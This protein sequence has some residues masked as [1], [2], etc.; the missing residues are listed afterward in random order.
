MANGNNIGK[1]SDTFGDNLVGRQFTDGSSQFT[2]GN[3]GINSGARAKDSREFSLGN[4]SEP[5]TLSTLNFKSTEEARKASSNS[6]EVFINYDRS[7]VSN[8]VLYGSL[9]DRLRVAVQ[10]VIKNFPAALVFTKLRQN[11]LT[12]NTATNIIFDAIEN[13]TT[14]DLELLNVH[15]PFGIDFTKIGKIYTDKDLNPIRNFTQFYNKYSL[16]IRDEEYPLTFITP[17]TGN[18]VTDTLSIEVY[19]NPFTGQTTTTENFFIKPNT[20]E[21]EEIFDN[22][23]DVEKFII[24][25]DTTPIYTANFD[26]P[27]QTDSGKFVQNTTSLT[28]PSTNSWNL[29]ITGASFNVYLNKLLEIADNFDAYKTN[30]VSRFLTTAAFKEFDTEDEKVDQILKIYGRSFDNIKTYIEGLAYMTNVTYDS[31]NNVP[32]ELL[33]NFAHMLGWKTPSAIETEGFLESI[34]TRSKSEY[35][36]KAQSQTPTELNSELYRRLVVNTAYLFKSKGT[37]K[38][39]EFLM[40][41]VGAPEALIEFNEHVYVAG[42]RVNMQKFNQ[43]ISVISGGSYYEEVIVKDQLFSATT[44]TFPPVT[45]TGYTF[46]TELVSV[47]T[48]VTRAQFPVDSQGY[49]LAPTFNKDGF[50]QAGAGWFEETVEHR[51]K[52]M[53]DIQT[54]VFTGNT[55]SVK[56]KLNKFT[57]GEPYL[58]LYRKF[59]ETNL[60]FDIIRTKDNKKSWVY[61]EGEKSKRLYTF[62]DRG[63]RYFTEDERLVLNVKNVDL[64]LN[65]GQGLTWDV[66]N[67]SNKFG[68]PFGKDPL[69]P[70]YPNLGGPDWTQIQIDASKIPF[71]EFADQFWKILINVKNR[72][73]IDD[74]HAGGYPTLLKVY[75]DYL[76]SDVAC[77]VPSNKYTYQKMIDYAEGIGDY[78]MRLVEQFIP[79]TT[80]WQGGTRYENSAF[81][82]YKYSYKHEPLC[83][84][85]ECFGSFISC[86]GPNFN[87]QLIDGFLGCN[88]T[89]F[90]GA[91]WSN[92][93]TLGGTVYNGSANG[94]IYYSSTTLTDIPSTS[95][96]LDDVVS[97]LSGI[98]QDVSDPNNSLTWYVHDDT[99]TDPDLPFIDNPKTIIVQGPCSEGIDMWNF[100]DGPDPHTFEL[101]T[102]LDMDVR[103]SSLVDLDMD[104]FV[105]Y[106]G[107]SMG[108]TVANNAKT[109]LQS[110]ASGLTG[111][112][113]NIYHIV[114]GAERWLCSVQYPWTGQM[115]CR[116]FNSVNDGIAWGLWN[117]FCELPNPNSEPYGQP[118][119]ITN[120]T[121]YANSYGSLGGQIGWTGGTKKALNIILQDETDFH[122]HGSYNYIGPSGQGR[123]SGMVEGR[124]RR[125][126]TP[127][128]DVEDW[129]SGRLDQGALIGKQI[130]T[131][132]CPPYS[133]SI[134]GYP[135]TFENPFNINFQ[136]DPPLSAGDAGSTNGTPGPGLGGGWPRINPGAGGC[137]IGGE[138]VGG[139]GNVIQPTVQYSGDFY[140]FR[141]VYTNFDSFLGFVYPI[142]RDCNGART[143]FPLHVYG[144][145]ERNTVNQA[146]LKVNPLIDSMLGSMS[147]ITKYNPYSGL[148]MYKSLYPDAV[149]SAVTVTTAI[150][151][152]VTGYTATTCFISGAT[153]GPGTPGIV[154]NEPSGIFEYSC[155]ANGDPAT[156]TVH[157]DNF[158]TAIS[159]LQIS[160]TGMT[161]DGTNTG[162]TANQLACENPPRCFY[163]ADTTYKVYVNNA[164]L[165][166][167]LGPNVLTATTTIELGRMQMNCTGLDS[168]LEQFGWGWQHNLGPDGTV[169]ATGPVA[170]F[171]AG[172]CSFTNVSQNGVSIANANPNYTTT[173]PG[174]GSVTGPLG[175]DDS[176]FFNEGQFVQDLNQFLE[177]QGAAVSELTGCTICLPTCTSECSDGA[178]AWSYNTYYELGDTVLG[179]HGNCYV[180][181]ELGPTLTTNPEAATGGPIQYWQ[182]A[183]NSSGI[184]F[185]GGNNFR[186]ADDCTDFEEVIVPENPGGTGTTTTV[187]PLTF[188]DGIFNIGGQDCFESTYSPCLGGDN[189]AS[190]VCACDAIDE[191]VE[192]EYEVG[193]I[194]CC[195]DGTAGFAAGVQWILQAQSTTKPPYNCG[196]QIFSYDDFCV[197][198]VEGSTPTDGCWTP[199]TETVANLPSIRQVNPRRR[200][201]LSL[202]VNDPRDPC[203]PESEVADTPSGP[204]GCGCNSASATVLDLDMT[205]IGWSEIPVAVMNFEMNGSN[206]DYGLSLQNSAYHSATDSKCWK[207]VMSLC[208]FTDYFR[209]HTHV[210][211]KGVNST[212]DYIKTST[213]EINN[214]D[215]NTLIEVYYV[216]GSHAYTALPKT[217]KLFL[218]IPVSLFNSQVTQS[219]Y[220]TPG[221]TPNS[222]EVNN[223]I[224]WADAANQI[225]IQIPMK[226]AVPNSMGPFEMY[227][228]FG[229]I[230]GNSTYLT[231][232][233]VEWDTPSNSMLNSQDNDGYWELAPPAT[234]TGAMAYFNGYNSITRILT[235][236]S[237]GPNINTNSGFEG[238][239]SYNFNMELQLDCNGSTPQSWE[240]IPNVPA[241]TPPTTNLTNTS[242]PVTQPC[243]FD[244][245]ARSIPATT[246]TLPESV[247]MSNLQTTGG[248]VRLTVSNIL[249]DNAPGQNYLPKNYEITQ[250]QIYIVE[251]Y[252]NFNTNNQVE[253]N[254]PV[255][256]MPDGKNTFNITYGTFNDNEGNKVTQLR[257]LQ[258]ITDKLGDGKMVLG[259]LDDT[260]RDSFERNLRSKQI[261]NVETTITYGGSGKMTGNVD[262]SQNINT[263]T[264]TI[265]DT[266]GGLGDW[267]T[268]SVG[269]N[270]FGDTQ[271]IYNENGT[272]NSFEIRK[273]P[274]TRQKSKWAPIDTPNKEIFGSTYSRWSSFRES[275][276]TTSISGLTSDA[277]TAYTNFSAYTDSRG[278]CLS[279]DLVFDLHYPFSAF[280]GTSVVPMYRHYS[281]DT[282]MPPRETMGTDGIEELVSSP[283]IRFIGSDYNGV[284][285]MIL[286]TALNP[287]GGPINLPRGPKDYLYYEVPETTGYRFQYKG[288]LYLC[289]ED[290]GYCDYLNVYRDLTQ[291]TFPTN[292]LQYKELINSAIIYQGGPQGEGQDLDYA[293]GQVAEKYTNVQKFR[294]QTNPTFGYNPGEGIQNFKA[295]VY[296][297][298]TTHNARGGAISAVTIAEFTVGL[299]ET[300]YPDA[301]E[302]LTL[303]ILPTDNLTNYHNCSGATDV[304][305]RKFDVY[306]DSTVVNLNKGDVVRLKFENQFKSTTKNLNTGYTST[307]KLSL[308]EDSY[309]SKEFVSKPWYRITHYPS[310]ATTSTQQMVWNSVEKSRKSIYF[311]GSTLTGTEEQ[312]TLSLVSR[313]KSSQVTYSK[314][315]INVRSFNTLT[316]LDI[317]SKDYVGPLMLVKTNTPTNHWVRAIENFDKENAVPRITDYSLQ[318]D[319]MITKD[320]SGHNCDSVYWNLPISDSKQINDPFSNPKNTILIQNRIRTKGNGS[321]TVTYKAYSPTITEETTTYNVTPNPRDAF[322]T[323][324]FEVV[325]QS[326]KTDEDKTIYFKDNSLIIGGKVADIQPSSYNVSTP[327]DT[328]LRKKYCQCGNNNYIEINP[329]SMEG[330]YTWCCAYS[331]REGYTDDIYGCA[332]PEVNK[333]ELLGKLGTQV[334]NY[335]GATNKPRGVVLGKDPKQ[336]KKI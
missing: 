202:I 1:G 166:P 294:K 292:D 11:F 290:N 276:K 108:N 126:N 99:P 114:N 267:I 148:T 316:F 33:T 43:R 81:H 215:E 249:E 103:R 268:R 238:W 322:N 187:D 97:I 241:W 298:K 34:L 107:T 272:F 63:T 227:K 307:I 142:V 147:A 180:M 329:N 248:A 115:P 160:Y 32:N 250:S 6:L 9:R 111:W 198:Y 234:Q 177:N 93:L 224:G 212:N 120:A 278:N 206:P 273:T 157:T 60:G 159:N 325:K 213:F 132:G 102:C 318:S 188:K 71:V 92:R 300:A 172:P 112:T 24:E 14:L 183:G 181:I 37:R 76:E 104:I 194:V 271:V 100:N 72:Q 162:A 228:S 52:E 136:Q 302:H 113:G 265:K 317:P 195:P 129:N 286:P 82:R 274:K 2:L 225:T 42:Q 70:P 236:S 101:E 135:N 140:T 58:N 209:L 40:R 200:E 243:P 13:E 117:N 53:V 51:G 305:S 30:L 333:R 156:G 134:P 237:G 201:V 29:V 242:V 18:T 299:N 158:N 12:G 222:G 334:L 59:P 239:S 31:T 98:T 282:L 323:D 78:W 128:G 143:A 312:G 221:S 246:T 48:S 45:V 280:T 171:N 281:G 192:F 169:D 260:Q 130:T 293:E 247:S 28:W 258:D 146:N 304:F 4:F 240:I 165:A 10:N 253:Y 330:C 223:M 285:P 153:W 189:P 251:N 168:G 193:D 291:G 257:W 297:E 96:W 65:V 54:S 178:K 85:L 336:P 77:G 256:A 315:P 184:P 91:T 36:G 197:N 152:T 245:S 80:I 89:V 327:I 19:G 216:Q 303:D 23:E 220:G 190:S 22:L 67:L 124:G 218:H 301:N 74:G 335:G 235:D 56:T 186:Q 170:G 84:D 254:T 47:D 230:N 20:K 328:P 154:A 35:E 255:M 88:G 182:L 163:T 44:N 5:I 73:T 191:N 332:E 208:C 252:P 87:Q 173:G 151:S 283:I 207:S 229:G 203:N 287:K 269:P 174:G 176:A 62:R 127:T 262:Y 123:C 324:T 138:Q 320:C 118:M 79:A 199:C 83:D 41:F 46:G 49:P 149:T 311:S 105:Y 7:K 110:W 175:G 38:A 264:K 196:Q 259:F 75:L 69:N 95:Q 263:N 219:T 204:G 61:K 211:I 231:T 17:T 164:G 116:A 137:P 279:P 161:A 55:P 326:C 15:N 266:Y 144:A 270:V 288:C 226:Q 185:L 308:G 232:V 244:P 210:Y 150:T 314:N 145:M 39:I 122:Y 214:I 16:F 90:S 106:D 296:L 179:Y 295:R 94:G 306:L 139:G 217:N 109:T 261:G 141:H 66:W 25:R 309:T 64:F 86:T 119:T 133:K 8:F 313:P 57:Y 68:C 26:I 3:F 21:T 284:R 131:Q 289:Y 155:D 125:V 121:D 331:P 50:F 310:T 167:D 277:Y 233:G 205:E 27:S 275:Y 321:T 319:S